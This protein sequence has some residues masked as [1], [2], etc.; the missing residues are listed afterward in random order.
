MV[1]KELEKLRKAIQREKVR[2][3]KASLISQGISEKKRLQKELF[4]LR[5]PTVGRIKRGFVI[6]AKKTG[7][8]IMTQARL[9]KARQEEQ[10]KKR[11]GKKRSKGDPLG[12]FAPLEI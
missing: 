4:E 2:V 7:R 6:L 1:D 8:G 3:R 10:A 11:K 5:N 9:I 12:I